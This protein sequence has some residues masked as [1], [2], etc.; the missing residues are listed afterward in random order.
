MTS[1]HAWNQ[2]FAVN[3]QWEWAEFSASSSQRGK[4]RTVSSLERLRCVALSWVTALL[5]GLVGRGYT[6][7]ERRCRPSADIF[8]AVCTCSTGLLVYIFDWTFEAFTVNSV[9]QRANH[10]CLRE[11]RVIL[12]RCLKSV[13]FK[14]K[15]DTL[16]ITV[17]GNVHTNSGFYAHSIFF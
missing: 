12:L 2:S 5:L 4:E 11:M 7:N 9:S 8:A 16:D 17:D 1:T 14:L 3:W 15:I 6:Q 10:S 13:R